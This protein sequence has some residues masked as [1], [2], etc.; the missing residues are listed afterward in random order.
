MASPI[1]GFILEK[2]TLSEIIADIKA[3]FPVFNGVSDALLTRIISL[4]YANIPNGFI[5]CDFETSYTAFLYGVAHNLVAQDALGGG[6]SIPTLKKNIASRTAGGLSISYTNL[7][8][9]GVGASIAN[10][11]SSTNYGLTMLSMLETCGL[12]ATPGGFV[13]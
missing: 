1:Q 5:Y 9:K 4:S 2:K 13:V 10:Y 6:S 12:T 7:E 8:S 11:F 3:Q